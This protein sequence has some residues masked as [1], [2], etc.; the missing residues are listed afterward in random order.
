MKVRKRTFGVL[1][2]GKKVHI[3]T[4]KAGDLSLSLSTLGAAWTSLLV[5]SRSN[6]KED[7]LL[8]YGS[9]DG[10]VNNRYYG[11]TVGRYANRIAGAKFS[12][13]GKEYKLYKNDGENTLHGGKLGFS[14]Q[15]WKAEA[16]EEQDGVFVRFELKSPDGD[17]GYPGNLRV[18]VS[19]GLTKSNE[20][21]A[22]YEAKT[23]AQCP[24]NLTNHAY[25][26]LAGEGSGKSILS[27]ELKLYSSS[28]V[29]V[30]NALIPTGR[31]L[32]VE[33][34]PL[35]FTKAKPIG[36]DIGALAQSSAGGYDHCFVING[37][38]GKLRPFAEAYEPFSGRA[39]RGFTTQPGVQFFSGNNI[40]SMPGKI[41]S[42]YE[43]YGGFC[44][45]TQ[46]FPDSPN[47]PE[48]PSTIFGP[49]RDYSEKAVFA[50]DW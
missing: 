5:P 17:D 14:R 44:L 36:R 12:L 7:I 35:D 18:A 3:F 30:D 47:R 2:N 32:S 16:Y 31:I 21:V 33:N 46:H 37:E 28:Y 22:D 38:P 8:G 40:S 41:G 6:E 39:M 4:L 45:E 23:D 20:I 9:F 26:N 13:A 1:P 34:S 49:D 10:Y 15:V 19:Y 27:T 42:V 11:V 43:K 25:F 48:F 29:E 24:V 50:F